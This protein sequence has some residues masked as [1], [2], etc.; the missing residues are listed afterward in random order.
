M[1]GKEVFSILK[2][3]LSIEVGWGEKGLSECKKPKNK[4]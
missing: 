3:P 2:M 1:D 4:L